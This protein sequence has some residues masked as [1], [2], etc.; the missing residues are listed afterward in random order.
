[1]GANAGAI[2]LAED[3]ADHALIFRHALTAAGFSNHVHVVADG[4][5]AILY[6]RGEG[7]Y[8]DRKIFPLPL[9][10]LLDL[11][12]PRM[13]G[14][15]VLDWLRKQE[16]PLRDLPVLVL[17]TSNYGPDIARAYKAGANSFLVKPTDRADCVTQMKGLGDFWLTYCALPTVE[18]TKKRFGD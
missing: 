12:M 9:L 15:G 8:S 2:L 11:K 14:F 6:L 18:P 1:V 7:M 17:T 10:L 16:A 3:N 5:Q 13:D 4:E